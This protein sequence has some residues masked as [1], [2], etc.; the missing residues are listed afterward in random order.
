MNEDQAKMLQETHQGVKR[1]VML[2]D[3][4][5]S[6]GIEGLRP[7]SDRHEKTLDSLMEER[8]TI[9][10]YVK[11]GLVGLGLNVLGLAILIFT[12]AQML[13]KFNGG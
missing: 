10:N 5:Q 12:V 2:V 13:Q 4:D 1:L 7:R 6:L 11:G 3:G 9:K 8:N